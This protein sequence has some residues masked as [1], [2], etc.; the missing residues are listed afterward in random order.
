MPR[1][2]E[3]TFDRVQGGTMRVGVSPQAPWTELD[4]DQPGG[5]EV[6]LL[7]KFA[8]QVD[9]Q[10]EWST[11][12][13]SEL[14]RQLKTGGLDIVIGGLEKSTPWSKEV[15]LTRPYLTIQ[16]EKHVIAV[17]QG[18]NRW[19]LE[20]EKFLQEHRGEAMRRYQQAPEV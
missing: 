10:I 20:L 12:A 8:D 7:E 11:G 9:A 4:G 5:I 13:E 16:D 15:G 19:L 14:L 1:D 2:P 3:G 6:A 18:E 17:R